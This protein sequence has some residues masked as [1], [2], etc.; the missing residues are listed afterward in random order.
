M[1]APRKFQKPTA[2]RNMTAQR[3][4]NG[5]RERDSWRAPSCRKLHASTV[6][7]VRGMTSAAEKNAP[8]A[9]CS[10]GVAREVEVVHRADHAADRVEDDVEVDDGQ[11][12]P[13]RD[14]AEQD[15]DVGDHDGR[16]E[17]QE[18]LDPEVHDPEAPEVGGREVDVGPG[19]Q[20]D[21]VEGR[22]RQRGE[23]EEPRHVAHVLAVAAV[24][25]ARGTA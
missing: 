16:E 3:C 12:R 18:V 10:A 22:D 8:S 9:M 15:E 13:A 23:E 21:G 7:K 25:A 6:R 4:G 14:D 20:P 17:L 5:V 1:P 11:G 19:E 2:T 24:R